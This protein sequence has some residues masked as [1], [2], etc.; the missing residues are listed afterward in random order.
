[1]GLGLLL[2]QEQTGGFDD[3][4]SADFVPTE[5]GGILLGGDADAV[6]VDDQV[7]VFHFDRTVELSV[8]RVILEHISHVLHV[9][10]VVDTD[11]YDVVSFLGGPED[12]TADT[13][14]AVDAYFDFFHCFPIGL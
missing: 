4:L 5:V 9:D 12:Q 3:V 6:A 7:S 13:S 1:M 8:D 2:G 14:E 10:E 11:D